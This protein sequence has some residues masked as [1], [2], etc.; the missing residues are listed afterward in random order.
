MNRKHAGYTVVNI[1]LHPVNDLPPEEAKVPTKQKCAYCQM[2][3]FFLHL[4]VALISVYF[5]AKEGISKGRIS[6]WW[7][8]ASWEP[9]KCAAEFNDAS[10][11]P[12]QGQH[13]PM[14]YEIYFSLLLICSQFIT[15]VSHFLR[16]N[17]FHCG[18]VSVLDGYQTQYG[19]KSYANK[20]TGMMSYNTTHLI[21]CVTK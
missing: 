5:T 19:V 2:L 7:G 13:E 11:C 6:A 3:L 20:T 4:V 18:W 21:E 15:A 16:W 8:K 9:E 10:I 17:C 12:Y 1:N 14:K